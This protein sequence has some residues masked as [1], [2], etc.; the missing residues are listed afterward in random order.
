MDTTVGI[1]GGG[2]AGLLLARLLRNA[3][4][5]SVT[6]ESRDRGYVESRQGAGILEQ[7]TV[8]TLRSAGSASAWTA[9]E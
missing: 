9:R 7:G 2:P 6:L 4:I 1:V 3:G 8:D 5:A